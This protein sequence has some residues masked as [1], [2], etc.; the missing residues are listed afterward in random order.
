MGSLNLG[1]QQAAGPG[2]AIKKGQAREANSH[3]KFRSRAD[4]KK[5]HAREANPHNKFRSRFFKKQFGQN[6]LYH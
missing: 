3:N 1:P 4:P 2:Q 6:S 5:G